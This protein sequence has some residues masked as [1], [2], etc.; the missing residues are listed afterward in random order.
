ME[1]AGKPEIE[2]QGYGKDGQVSEED[3]NDDQNI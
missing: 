1:T 2:D 3:G